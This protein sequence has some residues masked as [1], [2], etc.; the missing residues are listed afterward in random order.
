MIDQNNGQNPAGINNQNMD[1][2]M[3]N[4]G[5]PVSAPAADVVGTTPTVTPEVAVP[6]S[7]VETPATPVTPVQPVNPEP[8]VMSAEVPTNNVT[9]TLAP[10]PTPVPNTG[11]SP[12][13]D[14]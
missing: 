14:E 1:P 10:T 4:N 11:M 9:P 8:Q 2:N 6:A 7:P 3:V 5:M 12:M 13:P